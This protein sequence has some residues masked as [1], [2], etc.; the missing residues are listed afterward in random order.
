MFRDQGE[1]NEK[2]DN[3][4]NY[5]ESENPIDHEELTINYYMVYRVHPCG[6]LLGE[7]L[8]KWTG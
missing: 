8:E 2:N 4:E 5:K 1:N 3:D 7:F 6:S